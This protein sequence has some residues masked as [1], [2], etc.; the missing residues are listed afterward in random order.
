[1]SLVTTDVLNI[2]LDAQRDLKVTGFERYQYDPSFGTDYPT[3]LYD[4]VKSYY[5]FNELRD[6]WLAWGDD[7][8]GVNIDEAVGKWLTF[9]LLFG[10]QPEQ[11]IASLHGL[12]SANQADFADVYICRGVGVASQEDLG[13]GA[14][15]VPPDFF[16]DL[17]GNQQLF[18]PPSGL[19][20][21]KASSALVLP[22]HTDPVLIKPGIERP[23]PSS[24]SSLKRAR[25]ATI[26]RQA[27]VLSG[28]VAIRIPGKFRISLTP[29]YPYQR[30]Q[31]DTFE[32][33]AA[34]AIGPN[35]DLGLARSLVG[36]L[37][38]FA[39]PRPLDIAVERINRAR[40]ASNDT[41]AAIDYGIAL[42]VTLMY[43]DA[44][45]NQEISN[46]LG[47]RA[48]W[49]LGADLHHRLDIK[50]KVSRLY[51][52]RSDA[53]HR[54]YLRDETQKKFIKSEA[55]GLIV[56]CLLKV[57]EMGRFPDWTKLQFG[58]TG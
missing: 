23:R 51:S 15:L 35:P 7:G 25:L 27:L 11:L 16:K 9:K 39:D 10:E 52:A 34:V 49:L 38:K 32:G 20:I 1:M 18:A 54:G 22:F 4:R 28:S 31:V 40:S 55:D 47:M 29:E 50:T 30:N 17:A 42:E 21:S 24:S 8:F 41:D 33:E 14:Y 58:D 13:H 45:A 46:K 2:L 44:A 5:P 53:A 43:G 57:L 36:R 19:N 6:S 48:G 37:E 26:I 12:I 56:Q 3:R